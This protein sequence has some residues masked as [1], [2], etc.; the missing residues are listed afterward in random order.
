MMIGPPATAQTNPG[1]RR[2]AIQFVSTGGFYGA[3]RALLEL[4][5]FLR[6]QGWDSRIIAMEGAGAEELQ[7]RAAEQGI[8]CEAYATGGRLGLPAMLRRIKATLSGLSRAVVHSHGY[9]PDIL[10]AALG[11]PRRLACLA[12]CHS[13]YS[14]T[15]K[16]AMLERLDKRAVRRFDHVVAVS[17]EIRRTLLASGMPETKL[18]TIDNGI[19]VPSVDAQ[20]ISRIRAEWNL[21]PG[22]KVVV[23]VGRLAK[24]KRNELLLKAVAGLPPDMGVRIVLVGDG[25]ERAAL[26]DHAR[27]LGLDRR[28][29]FT[30]YR[31]DAAAIL[32]AADVMAITSDQ[33]GL[34]IV[35]LESMAVGCPIIA[36]PVG[37]IPE[38][39]T[40]DNAWMVP[41]GDVAAIVGALKESL[42]AP[43]IA[44]AKA[45]QARSVFLARHS[46]EAM[47]RR[48]LDLYE[49]AW[50]ERGWT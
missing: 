26:A 47:G 11:V 21:A 1:H 6:D 27:R 44:H 28:V 4:A 30:G 25:E 46:R 39:L 9:K 19:N 37:S 29:I 41:V 45:R 15:A 14:A 20:Q 24:S 33:E 48:Y 49:N 22:E 23:Q 5:T 2:V 10:L 38:I 12:T 32:A 17:G 40:Q 18:C 50:R 8:A 43:T 16:L 31:R 36:T 34:P 13:W 7:R 3:E 42:T 35:L